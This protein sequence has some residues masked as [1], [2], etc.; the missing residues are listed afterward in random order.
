MKLTI[1]QVESDKTDHLA[2][3][4]SFIAAR[5]VKTS[6]QLESR[7]DAIMTEYAMGHARCFYV[8]L[9]HR[10]IVGR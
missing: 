6:E 7:F 5:G 8:A 10:L 3:V 1:D 4:V 9:E 2:D